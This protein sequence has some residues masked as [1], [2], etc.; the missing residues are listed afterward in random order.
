MRLPL[1]QVRDFSVSFGDNE[2]VRNVSFNVSL[3][4]RVALVGQSGSGKSVCALSL[5]K[6]IEGAKVQGRALWTPQDE[7]SVKAEAIE[8]PQTLDL[9]K[10]SARDLIA[11]R[12]SDI[13]FVFQEPMTALNPLFTIG[14][15]IAEVLEIKRGLTK[16]EAWF[17]AIRLLEDTGI[18]EPARRAH[19]YPHQM[20]GGQRQR[21]VIAMALAAKPRLLI[22]DEPTTALDAS[23]RLQIIDLMR[24]LQEKHGMAV[25]LITHDLHLVDRFA[26]RVM[27]MEKGE[28]VEEGETQQVLRAPGHPYTR[29]LINSAPVRDVLPASSQAAVRLQVQHLHVNYSVKR[30]GWRGWFKRGAF[31]AVQDASFTLRAGQTLAVMGESGSGKSTLALAC[32]GL[33]PFQGDVRL[34]NEPWSGRPKTD[35]PMRRKMQV[36]F[37]DP[38]S[39]LSPRMTVLELLSEG[40]ALHLPMLDEMARLRRVLMTLS[41]VGLTEN[42]FPG[43]LQRYAHEFSGGQRQRLSLAR[44]LVLEPQVLVLDE[45]TSALDVSTQEQVLKLLQQLQRS[46]GLSYLLI[47]HDVQVVQALAHQVMVMQAGQIVEAGEAMQLLSQPRHPYTR[48]LAASLQKFV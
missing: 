45:P 47:T 19:S 13:A 7:A 25:L 14:D 27:V 46:R 17:E 36:V 40:I 18:P 48:L 4:D 33:L 6:L 2:V 21:A 29:R 26:E 1:L 10:L 35:L 15:Q 22:A 39:S 44:A 34:G 28:V 42:A 43:L 3:G 24:H 41:E 30:A 11:I 8:A 32:L 5:V 16:D 23:L 31:A 38:F 9:A 12:G 37:Q 20:S